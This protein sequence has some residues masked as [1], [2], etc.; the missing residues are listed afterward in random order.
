MRKPALFAVPAVPATSP[1]EISPSEKLMLDALRAMDPEYVDCFVKMAYNL[2]G[3][4][5][6]RKLP[7][8]R[9]VAIPIRSR[10]RK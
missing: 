2:A 10:S 6:V 1:Y 3:K 7:E 4:H 9:L 5:P 8:L